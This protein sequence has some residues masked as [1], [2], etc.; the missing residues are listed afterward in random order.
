[1]AQGQGLQDHVVRVPERGHAD[2]D[3]PVWRRL[4]AA[5]EFWD[6]V[7]RKILA[8]SSPQRGRFRLTGGSHVGRAHVG[9]VALELHEKVPDALAS[10]LRYL[11]HGSLRTLKTAS[12]LADLNELAKF[13]VQTFLMAV[14]EYVGRGRE[15][16]YVSEPHLG[17]LVG[18][19]IDVT[20]TLRLRA[21][22]LPHLAAFNRN[23]LVFDT[24]LNRV[25]YAALLEA[26]RLDR[27]LHLSPR[28]LAAVRAL[29]VAFADCRDAREIRLRREAIVR[30]AT[31]VA[32]RTEDPARR[33]LATLA[34]VVLS[35]E[36]FSVTDPSGRLAPRAWFLNLERLFES[37]V[38]AVL[39]RVLKASDEGGEL[40][41]RERVTRRIFSNVPQGFT[42]K[43]DLV[44]EARGAVTVG[45]VKYKTWGGSADAS[46]LY[47]LL[48]HAKTYD[49][50]R[51][52]LVYPHH[53]FD[54]RFL[55]RAKTE[56]DTWL[57]AIN[58]GDVETDVRHVAETVGAIIT[59]PAAVQDAATHVA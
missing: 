47:Q 45:D 37:S 55:G 3:A 43:P 44:I 6:L 22:G 54:V 41:P 57:F 24:P 34:G 25:V 29:S 10:L 4:S 36:S 19:R 14:R 46:D 15:R 38:R 58:I 8:V 20:R 32:E 2:V 5:P 21:R 50:Q 27:V 28:D 52:F 16:R 33:D 40:W 13:L 49:A 59:A 35:H 23:E 53:A 56:C 1:M 48:V 30:Y 31:D 51:C 42:A 17:S 26:E 12:P 7:D 9:G 11:G 18:G 39:S